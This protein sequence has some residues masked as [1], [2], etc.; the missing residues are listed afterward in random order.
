MTGDAKGRGIWGPL[1]R[2]LGRAIRLRC[3]NCGGG[4]LLESWFRLRPRCPRCGLR[5]ERGEH[6]FFLGAMMFNLVISEG[7]LALVMVGVVIALWPDVPWRTLHYTGMALM[8]LAPVFFYPFSKTIW[9]A[10]DLLMRPVTPGELEW[11]ETDDD[12]R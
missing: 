7:V 3:P 5:T 1:A 2:R 4:P 9:M 6:D 10:F 11:R 12:Q 8:V